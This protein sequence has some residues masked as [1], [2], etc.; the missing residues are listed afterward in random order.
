MMSP[1]ETPQHPNHRAPDATP[2]V[3]PVQLA[4]DAY[5]KSLQLHQADF[6]AWLDQL[7]KQPTEVD[8][9]QFRK[10]R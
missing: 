2:S 7:S 4:A 10:I 8:R 9:Y 6:L 5:L 1:P 3:P